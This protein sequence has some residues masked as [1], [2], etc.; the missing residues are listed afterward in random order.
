MPNASKKNLQSKKHKVTDA[1]DYARGYVASVGDKNTAHS[2]AL[3]LE[4]AALN[5]PLPDQKT[6]NFWNNIAG[7]IN[8]L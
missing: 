5:G 2:K 6:A 3:A 4:K 1:L 7:H 8:R